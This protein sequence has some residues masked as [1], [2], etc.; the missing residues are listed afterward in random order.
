MRRFSLLAFMSLAWLK[1]VPRIVVGAILLATVASACAQFTFTSVDFPG[2]A[3][4]TAFGTNNHGDIVGAYRI[5][6]PR[7]ALLIKAGRGNPAWSAHPCS[8]GT[9]E[10][11]RRH[12]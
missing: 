5:E 10:R 8:G 7:H 11:I 3:F 6:Q 2:A 12:R 4:T 9:R 1:F